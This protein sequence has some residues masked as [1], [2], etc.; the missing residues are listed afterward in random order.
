MHAPSSVAVCKINKL[1]Q[2]WQADPAN[3]DT[4]EESVIQDRMLGAELGGEG[5]ISTE[6]KSRF[7]GWSHVDPAAR[8]PEFR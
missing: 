8:E 1:R 4:V 6:R 7:R 5:E 3:Q 2:A